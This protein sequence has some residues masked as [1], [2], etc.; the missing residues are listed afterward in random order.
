MSTWTN[1]IIYFDGITSNAVSWTKI[2][3]DLMVPFPQ[4]VLRSKWEV[5][6]VESLAL[7]NAKNFYFIKPYVSICFYKRNI[8]RAAKQ[9][10]LIILHHNV[11]SGLFCWFEFFQIFILYYYLFYINC[12]FIFLFNCNSLCLA[13]VIFLQY[14][15]SKSCLYYILNTPMTLL[16]NRYVEKLV[17][18]IDFFKI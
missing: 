15:S 17:D 1:Q 4:L 2:F 14:I 16:L 8:R 7:Y 5:I 18:Q 10:A 13:I 12:H 11:I 3:R 9:R 6:P